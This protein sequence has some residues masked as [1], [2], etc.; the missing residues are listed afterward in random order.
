MKHILLGKVDIR[1]RKQPQ[2]IEKFYYE[3]KSGYWQSCDDAS[4][5]INDDKFGMIGSKKRD[6]ETG[7][8]QK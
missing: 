3:V 7:E 8:D 5:M 4:L 6:V 2:P 1:E